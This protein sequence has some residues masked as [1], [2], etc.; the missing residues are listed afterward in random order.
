[1]KVKIC[2]VTLEGDAARIAALGVDYIGLNFWPRSK[3]FVDVERAAALAAAARGAG[4][5]Q[6]VGVFVDATAAEIAAI[7]AR[8]G[9]DVIQLHGAEPPEVAGAIAGAAGRPVWKALAAGGPD[10]LDALDA[11]LDALDAWPDA[12]PVDA[13][14]LDTPTPERGGSG[15]TFDWALARAARLRH[16][17]RR[18]V[19]AGGL[20]PGN[21]AG[22]ITAVAPW[23]VDVASGVEAAPGVKDVGKV[24][25]FVAAAREAGASA[26]P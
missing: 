21:V 7:H 1:M 19:L 5:A 9:L 11:W 3:R 23:A 14:L 22:A 4:P 18:L 10:A 6:I 15:R 26:G 20:H 25:A 13:I 2:G 8:V 24:A 16:P 17:A 12:C